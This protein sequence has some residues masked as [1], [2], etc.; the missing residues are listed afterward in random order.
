M[1]ITSLDRIIASAPVNR[2]AAVVAGGGG[3]EDDLTV[4]QKRENLLPMLA[5]LEAEIAA[6]PTAARRKELGR[7]KF[8]LQQQLSLLRPKKTYPTYAQHFHEAAREM[9]A[10][11]MFRL[12]CDA[13]YRRCRQDEID[14][15]KA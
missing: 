5:R 8:E 13:A 3:S 7:Q 15:Q 11:A 10:P 4:R 9:L 6:A 2:S 1:K 14:S 12:I